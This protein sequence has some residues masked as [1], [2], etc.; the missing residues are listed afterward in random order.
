MIRLLFVLT[1]ALAAPAAAQTRNSSLPF[2]TG[3]RLEYAVSY[4]V[5]PAGTMSLEV[6]G[7]EQVD[8]RS[9]YHFVMEAR[10]NRAVSLV[11][12]LATKE[13]SWFD[14]HELYSLRY[15]RDQTENDKEHD[16]EVR[17]D[18]A[19]NIRI[20]NGEEKPASP[21]ALDPIATMYFLRTLNPRVGATYVLRNQADTGDNPLTVRVLK[22]E[23]IRVPAGTFDTFVVD[24]DVKTNNGVFRKGGEN[25]VWVTAD[26]RRIPVRIS[27]K[28]GLGS[29]KAELVEYDAR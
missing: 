17:Y 13:E 9:A 22:E 5:I 2:Q 8:G 21:R 1:L 29:F 12:E 4:G 26:A 7:I 25:R 15:R 16:K 19:R 28:I 20:E 3:E 27:S 10:S 6:V 11:V 14:A 18:Q 24:L 23:R